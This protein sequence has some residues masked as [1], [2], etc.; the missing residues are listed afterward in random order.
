MSDGADDLS[1]LALFRAEVESCAAVLNEGLVALEANQHD[2]AAVEPLMRAAHSI[3]GAAR[4][5]GLDAAVHVAHAM[6]DVLVAVQDPATDVAPFSPYVCDWSDD[7]RVAYFIGRDPKDG[8]LGVWGVPAAGGPPRPVKT[9]GCPLDSV[10]VGTACLDKYEASVWEIPPGN[11]EI[12]RR[13]RLGT[14][15]AADLQAAGTQRGVVSDDYG[16]GCPDT[17][18]ECVNFYAV[19]VPGVIPSRF[20]TWFQAAAAA[21]NSGKRLPTNQEWQ[22][23]ALGTPDGAPC[24]VASSLQTTGS[25]GCV[26]DAGAFDMVGNLVEWVADWVP[27]STACSGWGGFSDDFMCL[28][29]AST[30]PSGPFPGPGALIRGGDFGSGA[31][32]GAFAV[33]GGFSPSDP[34]LFGTVGFRASR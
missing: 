16:A 10:K 28:A 1:L 12:V 8:V 4:V 22:A 32:A 30:T 6:E 24:T 3:K 25:S 13:I 26:S 29:G 17:G 33:H 34:G 18:A 11:A 19:S 14:V 5:V 9:I 2:R 31:T 27:K 23:G 7:G 21:R 15:T 20:I